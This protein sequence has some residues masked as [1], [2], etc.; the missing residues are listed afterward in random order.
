MTTYESRSPEVKIENHI[1]TRQVKKVLVSTTYGTDIP[2]LI[3]LLKEIHTIFALSNPTAALF[4]ADQRKYFTPVQAKLQLTMATK[5]LTNGFDCQFKPQNIILQDYVK[6]NGSDQALI[7][8][9]PEMLKTEFLEHN[10]NRPYDEQ[11]RHQCNNHR[12]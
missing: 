4:G 12:K 5:I 8:K 10:T 6:K 2:E 7:R 3:D 9:D 1:E 11:K